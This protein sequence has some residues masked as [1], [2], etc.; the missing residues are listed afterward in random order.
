MS[1]EEKDRFMEGR[2]EDSCSYP[3]HS[4]L[5]R[6]IV[7]V[8]TQDQQGVVLFFALSAGWLHGKKKGQKNKT[9][10]PSLAHLPSSSSSLQSAPLTPSLLHC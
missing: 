1:D 10:A 8:H 9:V 7:D 2:E 5:S 3:S 6:Q 4:T